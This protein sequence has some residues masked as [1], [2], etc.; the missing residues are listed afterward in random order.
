M[1]TGHSQTEA[2]LD[3]ACFDSICPDAATSDE[4][5]FSLDADEPQLLG[6]PVPATQLGHS[7]CRAG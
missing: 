1:N 7:E 2:S 3:L 4:L 5:H 6:G